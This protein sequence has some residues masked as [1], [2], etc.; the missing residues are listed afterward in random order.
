MSYP[1]AIVIVAALAC[2][3]LLTLES[4]R[5]QSAPIELGAYQGVEAGSDRIF[6]IDTRTGRVAAFAGSVPAPSC[7]EWSDPPRP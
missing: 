6:L 5:S 7:S 2:G 1:A 3:T 4:A